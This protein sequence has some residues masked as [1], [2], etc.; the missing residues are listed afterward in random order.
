MTYWASQEKPQGLT[1]IEVKLEK[2]GTV[3]LTV[4]DAENAEIENTDLFDVAQAA[5]VDLSKLTFDWKD[6]AGQT[7]TG[8]QTAFI[9]QWSAML[10]NVTSGKYSYEISVTDGTN[11]VNVTLAK[12]AE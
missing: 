9:A 5:G 4:T 1:G 8:D 7:A 11:T 2:D 10:N 12:A 6:S 3:A